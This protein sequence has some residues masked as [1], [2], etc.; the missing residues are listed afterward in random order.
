MSKKLL[1]NVQYGM[2]WTS[3][4]AGVYGT[5][6]NAG[7]WK[8]EVWK[9]MGM[10]GMAF[11]FIVHKSCCPSSV[12]VYDWMA[13]HLT[14]MDQIGIYSDFYQTYYDSKSS[15][16]A[17]RQKD[18]IRRI[19]ESVDKGV[20]IVA[21]APTRV[22]EFGIING[23]DDEDGV[24]YVVDCSGQ[25]SDPLLYKNL[26][27]SDVPILAYQIF[28]DKVK[29]DNEQ[30]YRNSLK[31]AV[32]E[33]EKDFHISPDFASGKKAYTYLIK[34]LENGSFD[35]FGLAYIISVYYDSKTCIVQYLNFLS[36]QTTS[37]KGLEKA[38]AIYGRIVENYKMMSELFPFSGENGAGCTADRN[39][40]QDLMKLARDCSELES[41]AMSIIATS[42]K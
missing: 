21:W 2:T 19:K 27:K 37:L 38:A 26:G 8:D 3:Y 32:S 7:M 31:F 5:L 36:T 34:S 9:L 24:F 12:T 23:Y 30:V 20:C 4:I 28:K 42:L 16:F 33:W 29:V 1:D 10:T 15:T 22:L 6:T 40:A 14:M 41:Q 39:N 17:L 11:H 18:A 13:E 25:A 35:S